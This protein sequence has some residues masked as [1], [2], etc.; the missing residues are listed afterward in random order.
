MRALPSTS[1]RRS[2]SPGGGLPRWGRRDWSPGSDGDFY[3]MFR[4]ADDRWCAAI[5]DVTGKGPEAAAVTALAR[6]TLR[7]GAL[8]TATTAD[9]LSL[10]NRAMLAASTQRRFST[11]ALVA[12][13]P[14]GDGAI[15]EINLAGHPP[16]LWLLPDQVVDVGAP[17]NPPVGVFADTTYEPTHV[18]LAA[19]DT[20]VLYTDG[21]S[22]ARNQHDQFA[23]R[24]LE[25]TLAGLHGR[26][27][28]HLVEVA[29]SAV[30]AYQDG[31]P[32]DDLALVALRCRPT[33]GLR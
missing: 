33:S 27:A 9:L 26:S 14:T 6:Y 31:S 30:I 3:D 28:A 32:R 7:A 5:G 8:D 2:S 22:E 19:D 29:T 10:L 25:T 15:A 24:L 13:E 16:P 12:V 11:I 1:G 4:L 18:E 17:H 21:A 20:L 23:D